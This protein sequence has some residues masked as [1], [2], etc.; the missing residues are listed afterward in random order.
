MSSAEAKREYR[1][2][3]AVTD[4]IVR[5]MPYSYPRVYMLEISDNI[6]DKAIKKALETI[7]EIRYVNGKAVYNNAVEWLISSKAVT[8]KPKK[9]LHIFVDGWDY[10]HIDVFAKELKNKGKVWVIPTFKPCTN[11][12]KYL[13][14]SKASR[15]AFRDNDMILFGD[16]KRVAM[17]NKNFTLPIDRPSSMMYY[18]LKQDYALYLN[19]IEW[20][21]YFIRGGILCT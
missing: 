6:N 11:E 16:I 7:P 3:E 12:K 19:S 9:L 1:F 20:N 13:G 8:K 21:S 2:R 5:C 18:S 14:Y 4:A 10:E 15:L 17:E